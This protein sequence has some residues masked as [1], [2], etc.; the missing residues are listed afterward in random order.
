MSHA[1]T[2]APRVFFLTYIRES[3]PSPSQKLSRFPISR[4]MHLCFF[5]SF[6]SQ[7]FFSLPLLA[8]LLL[9]SSVRGCDLLQHIATSGQVSVLHTILL[10]PHGNGS[11]GRG[12]QAFRFQHHAC[13][14]PSPI[15]RPNI[16]F[17]WAILRRVLI[18]SL[19][20]TWILG[21]VLPREFGG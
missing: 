9:S 18:L 7:C 5:S 6:S 10:P 11:L 19:A 4:I 17:S 15:P 1:Y 16:C 13:L 20:T 12:F 14:T 2:H 21:R 3:Q 8:A